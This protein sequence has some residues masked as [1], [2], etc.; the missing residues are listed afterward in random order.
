MFTP[1]KGCASKWIIPG[2]VALTDFNVGVHAHEIELH[3]CK[4]PPA[5][6]VMLEGAD[7]PPGETIRP[8]LLGA[9]LVQVLVE[10]R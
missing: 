9:V 8:R 10:V 2:P 7:A 5:V 6:T 3:L 1:P 4:N